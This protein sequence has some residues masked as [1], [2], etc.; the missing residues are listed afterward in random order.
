MFESANPKRGKNPKQQRLPLSWAIQKVACHRLCR[1][2]AS[3]TTEACKTPETC[4]HFLICA[5][6]SKLKMAPQWEIT[7]HIP[8]SAGSAAAANVGGRCNAQLAIGALLRRRLRFLRPTW[9]CLGIP[10]CGLLIGGSLWWSLWL[11]CFLDADADMWRF[12]PDR[13]PLGRWAKWIPDW[14]DLGQRGADFQQLTRH[15]DG[16]ET[17]FP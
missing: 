9:S 8:V 6:P 3:E 11:G 4:E 7:L 14:G 17:R 12:R 13:R 2:H 16:L 5:C 10:C 1:G 15:I